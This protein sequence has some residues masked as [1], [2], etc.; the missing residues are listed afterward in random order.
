MTTVLRQRAQPLVYFV[1]TQLVSLICIR[2]AVPRARTLKSYV[3]FSNHYYY[4]KTHKLQNQILVSSIIG[5]LWG[6]EFSIQL[7]N[8]MTIRYYLINV[9]SWTLPLTFIG[10]NRYIYKKSVSVILPREKLPMQIVTHFFFSK[11]Q[12]IWMMMPSISEGFRVVFL[13]Y[14]LSIELFWR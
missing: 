4:S 2:N 8:V 14:S 12:K 7:L 3:T 5:M 11:K 13:R 6:L 1:Y 10:R 9:N